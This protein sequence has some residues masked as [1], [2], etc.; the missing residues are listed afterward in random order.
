MANDHYNPSFKF[1]TV[2]LYSF[3]GIG[4]MLAGG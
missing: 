3:S 4:V 2:P 1:P